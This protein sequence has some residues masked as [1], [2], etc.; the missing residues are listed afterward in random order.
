VRRYQAIPAKKMAIATSSDTGTPAHHTRLQGSNQSAYDTVSQNEGPSTTRDDSTAFRKEPCRTTVLP[1]IF[2]GALLGLLPMW[3]SAAFIAAFAVLA[4]LFVLFPLRPQMLGLGVAAGAIAVPQMIYL[5]SGAARIPLKELFHWGFT[6]PD[7]TLWRVEKYLAFTF[8]FK[9]LLIAV[10]LFFAA[11]L[12]RRMFVAV[13]ALILVAFLFRFSSVEILINH[14]FLNTWVT[15]INL[16]CA[17][18]LC[19]IWN[20]RIIGKI[21]T[22]ALAIAVSLGGVIEWFRIHND[23][24]VDVPFKPNPLS[25]WLQTNTNP[26]DVFLSDRFIL[27]PILLNGRRIFYGWPY[28][29]WSAG[30]PAHDRDVRYEQMFTEKNPDRLV[31]IL[32]QNGIRYIAIDNATRFGFLKGRLNEQVCKRYFKTVFEDKETRFGALTIYRVPD[33]LPIDIH[34]PGS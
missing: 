18:G 14:K 31:Q 19:W 28:F 22:V 3:N 30:Y 17:Y 29:A 9:W 2:S 27:H 7:P 33:H 10:A 12:Q 23:T 34:N 20:A 1:F 25:T 21:A 8:G 15:I 4:F 5:N 6:L 26:K 32:N 13:F 24:I 16:F 11:R